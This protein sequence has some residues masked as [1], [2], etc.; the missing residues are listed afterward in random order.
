M[1]RFCHVERY[2]LGKILFGLLF[3][4]NFLIIAE[5]DKHMQ[6]RLYHELANK[7]SALVFKKEEENQRSLQRSASGVGIPSTTNVLPKKSSQANLFSHLLKDSSKPFGEEFKTLDTKGR[8][9]SAATID[10][11]YNVPTPK[12]VSE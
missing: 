4:N 11:N 10:Y 12:T 2:I 6:M 7:P 3:S 8:K 5:W 1:L 9:N